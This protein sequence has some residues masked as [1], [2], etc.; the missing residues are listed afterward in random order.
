MIVFTNPKAT[1]QAADAPVPTLHV[2]K[3]KDFVR[4]KTKEEPANLESVRQ[5]QR[6]LPQEDV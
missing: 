6:T 4:R 3:L 1:V 5:V 2:E